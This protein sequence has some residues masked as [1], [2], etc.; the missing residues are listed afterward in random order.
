M[1]MPVR[2]A[3]QSI[4][5]QP[6]AGDI[7]RGVRGDPENCAYA[8]CV[9]RMLK[10]SVVFVYHTVAYI[11]VL[12]ERGDNVLERYVI[13]DGTK[14][15]LETF[16]ANKNVKPAGF[17]LKAPEYSKTLDYKASYSRRARRTG[18]YER[19]ET[20]R[21]EKKQR[22]ASGEKIERRKVKAK[23]TSGSFRDGTGFVRFIGAGTQGR[24]T[25]RGDLEEAVA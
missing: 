8:Q 4:L 10:T 24:L 9:K 17:K 22:E 20:T 23:K 2:D 1:G 3:E 7:E 12:N 15:Y 6:T 19:W 14:E 21:R 13:Q 25:K 18:A 11:E 16:D 5:V